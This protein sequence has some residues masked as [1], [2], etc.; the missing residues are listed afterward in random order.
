MKKST[1]SSQIFGVG[2]HVRLLLTDAERVFGKSYEKIFTDE[3]FMI[4]KVDRELP[5][6]YWV[7]DLKNR[8]IKGVV[9]HREMKQVELP[10]T[11][12]VEKIVKTTV[13]PVTGKKKYLVRWTG[14]SEDFDSYVDE[15][16]KL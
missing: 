4:R 7:S 10:D 5:V 9:Y 8:P 6:S 2:T 16:Y 3:I 13:D 12:Y 11:Y 14:F 1:S 15:I